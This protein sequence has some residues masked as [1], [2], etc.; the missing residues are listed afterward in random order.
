[1]KY[2][3]L[4]YWLGMVSVATV[5]GEYVMTKRVMYIVRAYFDFD[6]EG[7]WGKVYSS[8]KKKTI[9][10]LLDAYDKARVRVV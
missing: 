10:E 3:K 5:D 2:N 9:Q 4:R 1:M 6:D 7:W 8:S